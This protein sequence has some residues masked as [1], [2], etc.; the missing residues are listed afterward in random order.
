[1]FDLLTAHGY[2]VETQVHVGT[3]RIDLVVEGDDDRRLAIECDGDRYHGPEQWPYDMQ[4]QRTLERA[5]WT[6]WRCFASTFVRDRETVFEELLTELSALKISPREGGKRSTTYTEFREWGFD[7][8]SRDLLEVGAGTPASGPTDIVDPEPSRPITTIP[9]SNRDI[10]RT[11]EADIQ[12]IILRLM[13]DGHVWTNAALKA[14]IPSKIALTA[15]DR[16]P[17]PTRPNEEK[18]EELVNNALTQTGRSNSLYAQGLI[19]NLGRGSHRL[20]HAGDQAGS[21]AT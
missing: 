9:S 11:T 1:M 3:Y 6:V 19:K 2:L 4:R 15:G 13:S 18:W 17:S 8:R 5:G 21:E 20:L 16:S 14:S 10:D 12:A 7:H